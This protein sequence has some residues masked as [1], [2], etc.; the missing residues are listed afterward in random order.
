LE[1]E[2][3]VVADSESDRAHVQNPQYCISSWKKH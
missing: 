2:V 3:C 1:V